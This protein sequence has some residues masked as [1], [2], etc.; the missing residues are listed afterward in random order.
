MIWFRKFAAL[1]L[2]SLGAALIFLPFPASLAGERA[3]EVVRLSLQPAPFTE[4]SA[5]AQ[6]GD[7]FIELSYEGMDEFPEVREAILGVMG[8]SSSSR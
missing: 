5:R 2:L 1:M 3:E 8:Q 4:E 6:F 7:S